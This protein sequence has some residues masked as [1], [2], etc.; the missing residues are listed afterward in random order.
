MFDSVCYKHV[1]D[2]IRK[3]LDDKS[4]TMIL[5]GYYKTGA[6][7]LFSPISEKII[8]SIDIIIDEN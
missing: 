5:V 4:V 8:S 2:A 1:P 3:K 6:Y 7:R